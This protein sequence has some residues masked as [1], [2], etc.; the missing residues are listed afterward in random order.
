MYFSTDFLERKQHWYSGLNPSNEPAFL[1]AGLAK[2]NF[3]VTIIAR[4]VNSY[5][6]YSEKQMIIQ[7]KLFSLVSLSITRLRGKQCITIY[8]IRS[9]KD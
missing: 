5:G 1:P 8:C 6:A 3:T 2:N 7:V 4:V 9:F